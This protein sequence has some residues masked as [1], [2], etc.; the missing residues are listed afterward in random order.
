[1]LEGLSDYDRAGFG[2]MGGG[3]K[4]IAHGD[5]A[6]GAHRIISGAGSAAAPVVLPF[7]AAGAPAATATAL[8][9][10]TAGQ[11]AGKFG[12]K[13]LG[14]TDDQ[15]DLAG[16][17]TGL[18]AG[19]GGSKIPAGKLARSVGA[20]AK[21]GVVLAEDLP[22]VGSVVKGAKATKSVAGD[23]SKIWEK[24][25]V[26]PGAPLPEAPDPAM[27]QARGLFEGTSSPSDPAAGLGTIKQPAAAAPGQAGSI[28]EAMKAT[29]SADVAPGFKRG[30]LQQL[31]DNSV[32]AKKLEP[33][34]PLRQQFD[35]VTPT[36]SPAPAKASAAT[37]GMPE[38]HAPLE[39]SALRSYKYDPAA[40]EFE[41][42]P[43]SGDT[44]YRY[45]DVRPEAAQ[46]FENAPSKGK[47][48]QQIKSSGTL[49]AKR[50]NGKWVPVK[51]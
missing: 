19:F 47:A 15:A 16:D 8:A 27:L 20:I 17:V 48:F 3:V 14:A 42:W 40:H 44:A 35:R 4:D 45:G 37:P 25:G 51:R 24:P 29:P 43:T 39:S 13:A 33:N 49:V 10:G 2:E 26:Y 30:S 41:A 23:L 31:L 21:P 12:A 5:F 7:A 38:G 9:T 28:A 1:M 50:I 18:A 32:G 6:K 22:V 11:Y 46:A 34:V 36:S